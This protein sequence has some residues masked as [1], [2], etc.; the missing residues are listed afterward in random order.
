MM[1]ETNISQGENRRELS[2]AN[3]MVIFQ[4]SPVEIAKNSLL[5]QH[6]LSCNQGP[7]MGMGQSM[8]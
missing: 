2:L 8:Y 7:N 4:T 6:L 5:E 1:E 3:F